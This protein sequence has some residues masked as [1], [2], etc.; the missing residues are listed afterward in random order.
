MLRMADNHTEYGE[1]GRK[2]VGS[3]GERIW[4]VFH[5]LHK[6]IVKLGLTRGTTLTTDPYS[7]EEIMRWVY[8]LHTD[9]H[10][11]GYIKEI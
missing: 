3:H 8:L 4:A 7:D 11:D 1:G 2:G 5:S 10:P 6:N 9:D